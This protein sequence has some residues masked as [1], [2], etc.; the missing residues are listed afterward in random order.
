MSPL[1]RKDINNR[2]RDYVSGSESTVGVR[3]AT[4]GPAITVAVA[5]LA[6]LL[7]VIS[8]CSLLVRG[9]ASSA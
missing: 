1:L 6:A 8:P 3:R 4:R 9:G 7:V 5:V 2:F